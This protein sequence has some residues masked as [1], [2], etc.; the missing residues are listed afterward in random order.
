MSKAIALNNYEPQA[1][2]IQQQRFDQ[3]QI[4]ILKNS[5]CKGVSNEEFEV[6]LMACQKTQ[7]DPFMRQIYAVKR[8]AKKADG[9]WG[10]TMTIQTG[11]DGYRLIAE[12]TERYA[13]GPEP[14][15]VIEGGQL[16]SATS[17]IKKLTK[18]GTWHT[19]SASAYLDEYCQTFPDRQTGE[20]KPTGMWVNMPKTMLAKCAEAQALRKAFPAEMSGVYTKEEMQQAD[21]EDIT[22]KISLEQ[23]SELQMILDECDDK[24]KVWVYDYI[25]KQY[26][27]ENL[28]ELPLDIYDRMKAA[29][30][31]NMEQNYQKQ[32]AQLSEPELI[33]AEI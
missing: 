7:L 14:T 21:I 33:T 1:V 12:R 2:A 23:A 29:A 24:Y 18:D 26:K 6:F 16:V 25:K 22:P 3:K 4:D 32:R 15:Y 28:A 9:S 27:T 31:K 30:V 10:E 8:K 11:I 19:V 17:Y 20:K 5:I 13:P